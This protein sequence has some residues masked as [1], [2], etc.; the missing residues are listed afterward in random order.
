MTTPDTAKPSPLPVE[1]TPIIAN[2]AYPRKLAMKMLAVA[3][4]GWRKL[5]EDGLTICR[6]PSGRVWVLGSDIIAYL[7]HYQTAE[8]P[9]KKKTAKS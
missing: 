8:P 6:L 9:K 2:A 7:R 3:R 5:R 4:P 1:M